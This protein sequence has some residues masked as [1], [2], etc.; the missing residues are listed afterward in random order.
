MSRGWITRALFFATLFCVTFQKLQWEIAGS[1]ELADI[2]TILFLVAFVGGQV[3]RSDRWLP[4]AVYVLLAFMAVLLLVYLVGFFNIETKD[5]LDQLYKGLAKFIIHF[6]FLAAGVAY[7]GRRSERFYWQALGVFCGGM[8]A[9]AAYGAL[10][11][12]VA[13]RGGDLD[14]K[15]VTPLTGTTHAINVYGG[16]EG[17]SIYRPNAL[18]G[19]PNHLAVM[20]IIP[21]VI[22]TPIYLRLERKHRLRICWSPTAASSSRS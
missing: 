11:L 6:A 1:V 7:L 9:N 2:L 3:V 20:L 14:S 15:V 22:L 4:R 12:A 17:Q 10:Q 5:A 13:E 8:V 18:A 21:L 19:D 16:V